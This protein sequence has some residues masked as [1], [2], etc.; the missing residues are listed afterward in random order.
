M[1]TRCPECE[2]ELPLSFGRQTCLQCKTVTTIR[3][4]RVYGLS[5]EVEETTQK[6]RG[7][8]RARLDLT[9]GWADEE[10]EVVGICAL[11]AAVVRRFDLHPIIVGHL[12]FKKVP[13]LLIIEGKK[14]VV[15]EKVCIPLTRKALACDKPDCF[16]RYVHHITTPKRN[17][18]GDLVLGKDGNPIYPGFITP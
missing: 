6:A 1:K 3:H 12:I 9:M 11:C 16:A 7:L 13:R 2:A 10:G 4:H 15:V 17:K 8:L 14:K 5:V 18:A